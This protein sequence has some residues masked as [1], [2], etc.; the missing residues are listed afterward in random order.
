M[1]ILCSPPFRTASLTAKAPGAGALTLPC[2]RIPGK[3]AALRADRDDRRWVDSS[4]D[5][6]GKRT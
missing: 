6:A 4:L 2:D 5:R 1:A 3:G